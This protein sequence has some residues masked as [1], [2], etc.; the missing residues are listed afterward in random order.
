MP[1]PGAGTPE[2]YQELRARLEHKAAL[3]SERRR[4]NRRRGGLRRTKAIRRPAGTYRGLA[5]EGDDL[6]AAADLVAREAARIATANGMPETAASISVE[7]S[8]TSVIVYSD[9]PAAYPNEVPGIRHPVYGHPPWVTNQYRPFLKP[10]ADAKA[11][12]AMERYAQKLD[13]W[14]RKAGFTDRARKASLR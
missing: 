7:V 9:A 10:A 4:A 12:E 8:G 6:G 14:L 11:S 5:A 2:T 1:G 3:E 13:G